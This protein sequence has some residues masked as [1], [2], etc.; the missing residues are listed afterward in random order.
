MTGTPCKRMI[1]VEGCSTFSNGLC[2]KL[3]PNVKPVSISNMYIID[4]KFKDSL[5]EE[6][7]PKSA[8]F[9]ITSEKNSYGA[10]IAI[11]R[12]GQEFVQ[13]DHL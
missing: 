6:N 13:R 11:W 12:E 9:I 7:I 3:T 8:Q 1:H 2:Y 10:G 5:Q 4:V